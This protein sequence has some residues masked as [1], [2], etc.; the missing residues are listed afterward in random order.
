MKNTAPTWL[1]L[2]TAWFATAL[3]AKRYTTSMAYRL[4]S[5]IRG[6][7]SVSSHPL[8]HPCPPPYRLSS[9]F[10]KWLQ[11]CHTPIS[12][13]SWQIINGH[14]ELILVAIVL[15]IEELPKCLY[16]QEAVFL[17]GSGDL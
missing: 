17:L 13:K 8:N 11:I 2:V 6:L 4:P 9:Y 3:P 15:R 7:W 12:R 16:Q 1:P 10:F 14:S 5:R